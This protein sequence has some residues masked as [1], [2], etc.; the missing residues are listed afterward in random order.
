M[1]AE[2]ATKTRSP[3]LP[4]QQLR[5][6]KKFKAQLQHPKAAP[7]KD[8]ELLFDLDILPNMN[9][10]NIIITERPPSTHGGSSSAKLAEAQQ[11]QAYLQ[12][13][14]SLSRSSHEQSLP[15]LN[16]PNTYNE[17]S[18]VRLHQPFDGVQNP[19][20]L[21]SSQMSALPKPKPMPKRASPVLQNTN[22]GA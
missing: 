18:T 15:N 21:M 11:Y 8:D 12:G 9:N 4:N 7:S 3:K 2:G 16:L 13:L 14:E 19:V 5:L 10:M 1:G 20:L 6:A 22:L 17:K